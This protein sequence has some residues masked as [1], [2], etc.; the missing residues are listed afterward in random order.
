[1]YLQ[2]M[3]TLYWVQLKIVRGYGV[4]VEDFRFILLL[5]ALVKP[6]KCTESVDV[7]FLILE[8]E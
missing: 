8:L 7:I 1:M 4:R 3:L 6:V 5:Q 2:K